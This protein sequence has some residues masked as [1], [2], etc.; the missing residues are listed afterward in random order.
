MAEASKKRVP[1]AEVARYSGPALEKA[2]QFVLW[3]IPAVEKFPRGQRFLLKDRI[4]ITALEPLE[5]LIEATYSQAVSAILT[6]N[7]EK[8]RWNARSVEFVKMLLASCAVSPLL[9]PEQLD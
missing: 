1:R 2:Y 6:G 7:A 5:G 4:Q 3:L 8:S 9:F